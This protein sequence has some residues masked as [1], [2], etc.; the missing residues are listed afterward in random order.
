MW[1]LRV[2]SN[3]ILSWKGG[4]LDTNTDTKR[5]TMIQ[6]DTG[7]RWP[8]TSQG[9]GPETD[10]FLTALSR[11]QLCR[12]P[13]LKLLT[14]RTVRQYISVQAAQFVVLCH[15]HT[16]K[17]IQPGRVHQ[18]FLIISR[19]CDAQQRLE[20]S[21]WSFGNTVIKI[22]A[23]ERRIWEEQTNLRL[24]DFGHSWDPEHDLATS[25]SSVFLVLFFLFS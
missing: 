1:P 21:G 20:G 8:Y 17:L 10:S 18:L 12:H 7:R 4:N 15:G 2:S 19:S 24:F 16:S 22:E 9:E 13:D 14:F 25:Q 5:G 6:R 3:T 11:N 23:G